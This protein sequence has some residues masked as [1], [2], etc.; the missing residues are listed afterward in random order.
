MSQIQPLQPQTFTQSFQ[1]LQ[2]EN[3]VDTV[4]QS[5]N[6][7]FLS[8]RK[9][10]LLVR[11]NNRSTMTHYETKFG[12]FRNSSFI[13][14]FVFLRP[15]FYLAALIWQPHFS[16]TNL[17]LK[18]A[19]L[20]SKSLHIAAQLLQWSGADLLKQ[21]N[22]FFQHFRRFEPWKDNQKEKR[23]VLVSPYVK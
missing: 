1:S 5:L 15:W 11:F 7:R 22:E 19:D 10:A 18:F 17:S 20:N 3:L 21:L 16:S 9:I 6:G 2:V 13:A 8:H 14:K 12:S 23:Y 4:K